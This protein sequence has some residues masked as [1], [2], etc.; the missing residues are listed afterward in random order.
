MPGVGVEPP[1]PVYRRLF[2]SENQL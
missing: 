2:L 1:V